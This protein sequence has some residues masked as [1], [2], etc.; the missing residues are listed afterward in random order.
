MSTKLYN[1]LI[2]DKIPEI[3]EKAG[4][5][6]EIEVLDDKQYLEKL[7]EKLQEELGEFLVEFNSENDE[8]A[9]KELADLQEVIYAIVRAIGL[10]IAAFE[11]IRESKV[12]KNGAFEKKLLLK[13]VIEE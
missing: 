6:C 4:K 11:K 1:K 12:S 2:R 7:V 9:I 3:I 10:D 8:N 13:H 5:Q